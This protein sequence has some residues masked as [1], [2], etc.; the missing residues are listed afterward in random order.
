MSTID[1]KNSWEDA[2]RKAALA[3]HPKSEL[4]DPDLD[5]ASGLPLRSGLK[6]GALPADS[7]GCNTRAYNCF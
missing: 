6:A 1:F 5:A 3:S 2:I 4:A 7:Y